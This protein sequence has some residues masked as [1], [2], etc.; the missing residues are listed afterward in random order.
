VQPTSADAAAATG[1]VVPGANPYADRAA[2]YKVDRSSSTKLTEPI[3]DTPRTV[4]TISKEVIQDKAATSVR[5][6]ARTTPGVT[7]GTGE[8]GNPFGDRLFIRGFD[9]RND[10][11]ING[12]RDPGVPLRENFNTEQIEILKGPSATIGGRGTTGGAVNFVTKQAAEQNFAIGTITLGTDGTKRTTADVNQTYRDTFG[13]RL[14]GMW[15]DAGVAGRDEVF[16][17]RWGG[18]LAMFWKPSA[19]FKITAD[20]YHLNLDALPDWGVPWDSAN[21][22]PFT[23]SGVKRTNYYGWPARDFQKGQQDVATVGLELKVTP[24]VTVN[25][26]FRYGVSVIDYVASA[27]ESV[28][29]TDPDPAN[30]TVQTR[31]K[32]RW[33]ENEVVANQTD[34]TWKLATFGWRHTIVA[35]FEYSRELITRDSYTGLASEAFG[36]GGGGSGALSVGLW[37]PRTASIPFVGTPSRVGRPI[38]VQVD[39]RAAYV[40]DTIKLTDQWILSG[41]VRFDNYVLDYNQP[42]ADG[43]RTILGRE[44]HLTNYNIGLTYKPL[45]NGSIYAAYATSSNPVGQEL[46]GNG[47]SYGGIASGNQLLEP[48]KNTSIEFGTKWELFGRHLLATAAVFQT[49]KEN[50]REAEGQLVFSS[51]KYRIRGFEVGLGGKIGNA[52]SVYAGYVGLESAV[53]ESRSESNIDRRLANIAHDSFN[54]LAKYEVTRWLSVGGQAT[55]RGQIFGGT[56]ARNDNTIGEFWRFDALAEFKLTDKFTLQLQGLNLTDTVYYDALYRS[57]TPFVYIAPGRVG[58]A[59]LKIKY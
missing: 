17:N 44:D 3:L 23:E 53:L 39:T 27:P 37:N 57:G 32:S 20:Y 58:Y 9:A 48:E 33:Q 2:P 19:V 34:L 15:Q 26:R 38:A 1:P 14:N 45:P 21:R 40:L 31:P 13:I 4:T 47:N 16:D 10:A 7:L 35:G 42:N 41:G 11:Y 5:D 24:D 43:T 8:G 51:G 52:L 29:R 50:A 46:D 54:M 6:L 25:S 55:Y 59:T 18:A 30:W 56:L 22:R 28:D 12:I 49:E 36:G